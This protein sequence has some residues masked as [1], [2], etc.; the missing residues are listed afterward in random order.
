MKEQFS[1]VCQ[2]VNSVI[3]RTSSF[4]NYS[5]DI[6]QFREDINFITQHVKD[7]NKFERKPMV[8]LGFPTPFVPKPFF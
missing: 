6:R 5:K 7:I 3:T 8:F 2:R 4:I 1:K